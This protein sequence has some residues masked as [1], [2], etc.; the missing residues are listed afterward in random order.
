[1]KIKFISAREILDSRGRPTVEAKLTLSDGTTAK[2]GVPSG[3][4]TGATEACELRDGDQNR[5]FGKGV[6]NAVKNVNKTIAKA[7]ENK[8]FATQEEL[9][10]A[11]IDLDG[12]E[13]KSKL[14]GNAILAVSMAFCRATALS[15]QIPL[16]RYFQDLSGNETIETPQL[17]IL[18]MEGGE[19]GNWVT[20][21]QEYMVIPKREIFTTAAESIRAGAEIW[22]ATHDILAGKKYDTAVGFEG[23]F[24]PSEIKSNIEVFEI[25]LDG[26]EKAG[27]KPRE[28]ILLAID[29]ASS[30]F[31]KEGR[32][33]LHR[34]DKILTTQDWLDVQTDWYKRYP[35]WSVEDPLD[36]EDWDG[37][38]QLVEKIGDKYQVVGDD[39]LTTNTK[40]IQKAVDTKAVNSVLIKINQIGTI[41]ETIE[42]IQ[43][44][45]KVGFT[46]MISHRG[47][48]TNDDLIADLA[49]GTSSWQTKFGGPCRGERI[50]KYNRLLEIEIEL[51]KKKQD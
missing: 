30:E 19:H 15:K 13:N 37:W 17:A 46:T 39:L 8:E 51:Q 9:D 31:Y 22:K 21:F 23:A 14:G 16:Y 10:K 35:I 41:T 4:S 42:A 2:G 1:M 18:I 48:E 50:A 25:I 20:D 6:L 26:V 12:T 24:S 45:D 27:Y 36:Q 49:M 34:E 32:Y 43:L 44:S 7:I 38:T 11:L 28:E 47:G 29:V 33:H 3:A 5:Y 40:R